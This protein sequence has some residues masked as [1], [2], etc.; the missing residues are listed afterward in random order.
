MFRSYKDVRNYLRPLC[1]RV[2]SAVV[3][4]RYKRHLLVYVSVNSDPSQVKVMLKDNSGQDVTG[5]YSVLVK[6]LDKFI[7][8][9]RT[10]SQLWYEEQSFPGVRYQL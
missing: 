4:C 1:S 9:V 7:S 5:K 3:A 10:R 8:D 6:S 2:K